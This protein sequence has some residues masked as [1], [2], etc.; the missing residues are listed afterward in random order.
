MPFPLGISTR[1]REAT[2][3]MLLNGMQLQANSSP[4]NTPMAAPY[5]TTMRELAKERRNSARE[6]SQ[7]Q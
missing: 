7:A 1:T 2:A 6:M 3:L 4:R 5:T